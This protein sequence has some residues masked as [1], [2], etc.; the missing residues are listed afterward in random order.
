MWLILHI[1]RA[2]IWKIFTDWRIHLPHELSPIVLAF[3][4]TVATDSNHKQ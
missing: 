1:Y 3:F 2:T 4:L